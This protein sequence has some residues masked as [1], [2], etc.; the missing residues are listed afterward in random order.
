MLLTSVGVL[1][2]LLAALYLTRFVES[3]LYGIERL[4]LPT[5]LGAGAVMFVVAGLAAYLPARRAGFVNPM[6]ILRHE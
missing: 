4:D 3:Q 6:T 2:G 1:L 5:F